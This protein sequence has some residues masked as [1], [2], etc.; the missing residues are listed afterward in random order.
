MTSVQDLKDVLV[1]EQSRLAEVSSKSI[2]AISFVTSFTATILTAL[3]IVVGIITIFG[4][5]AIRAACI[6]KIEAITEK[7]IKI[8]I[9]SEKFKVIVEDK[10]FEYMSKNWENNII[11]TTLDI[12]DKDNN[13][14]S[15]FPTDIKK[16]ERN[17]D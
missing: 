16:G 17:D 1:T 4:W 6:K 15:P 9:E 8:Y 14:G 2:E 10:I 7:Q 3:A 5:I 11:S 12:Y 13:E